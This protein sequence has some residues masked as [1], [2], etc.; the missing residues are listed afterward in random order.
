MRGPQGGRGPGAPGAPGGGGRGTAAAPRDD[1]PA[2]VAK[3]TKAPADAATG[4]DGPR[5]PPADRPD[6]GARGP[7]SRGPGATAAP[8]RAGRRSA[9]PFLRRDNEDR[10]PPAMQRPPRE[11][12]RRPAGPPRG[13]EDRR[14]PFA[15]RD[16]ERRPPFQRRDDRGEDRRPAG[17]PRGD[18]RRPS[19]PRRDDDRR[20]PRPQTPG[21]ERRPYG[22]PRPQGSDDRRPP[23]VRRDDDRR[24][25]GP[26]RDDRPPY[27]RRD[28]RSDD[29]RPPFPRRDDDRRPSGPPRPQGGDDR[30]P[31]FPRRDDDRRPSVIRREDRGDDRRPSGPP[32]DDRAWPPRQGGAAPRRREPVAPAPPPPPA[33]GAALAVPP[34]PPLGAKLIDVLEIETRVEKMVAGGDCLAR[35]QGVPIFIPRAAPGDLVRARIVERRPDYGRAAIVAILEPG[36]GRRADPAP[37]L[38]RTGLCDLQHLEDDLQTRLKVQAVRETLEHLGHVVVPADVEVV[39]GE[40]WGYRLR[41]Q[42]HTELDPV[43]GGV[44]VGYHARGTNEVIP[45]TGCPLLVPELEEAAARGAA[46]APRPRFPLA[47]RPRGGG[48]R[49]GHRGAGDRGL[50]ARRG[51][52]PR[53]GVHLRLRRPRLLPGAPR[54]A[55]APGRGDGR[56]VDRGDGGRPLRRRR[57]V[58]PAAVDEVRARDGGRVRP[59]RLALRAPQHPPQLAGERRG[60]QSGGRELDPAH[61]AGARPGDRRPPPRRPVARGEE[62]P[63]RPAPGAPHLRLLPPRRPRPRPAPAGAGHLP[64]SR[65]SPSST[66]FRRPGTW[67]WWCRWCG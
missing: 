39:K 42:V 14:P 38:S 12:E 3:V 27:P 53:R 51:L 20:P 22:P 32:R 11:G 31:S 66:S 7:E 25:P 16:D 24:P 45:V 9:T 54:P 50:A 46:G 33:E 41:T 36:P 48:R 60:G 28:D 61:A 6:R 8:R 40:P 13:G 57:P 30:R 47:D 44:R 4:G 21:G 10:R 17:P 52:G 59:D 55:A 37:E 67:R 63:G 62:H 56:P 64:R 65:A 26:P 58:H 15:R 19:F 5:R 43:G 49:R 23:F 29:R 2:A 35:F 1:R 34:A 18:D